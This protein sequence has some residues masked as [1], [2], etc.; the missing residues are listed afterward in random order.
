MLAPLPVA[1]PVRFTTLRGEPEYRS[2]AMP[3]W[4]S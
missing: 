1:V 4:Q 2:A 3:L